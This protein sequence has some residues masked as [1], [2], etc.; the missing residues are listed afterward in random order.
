MPS[1]SARRR[2]RT[3]R[4]R[5]RRALPQA[6]GEAKEWTVFYYHPPGGVEITG[7]VRSTLYGQIRRRD[8][9]KELACF[10]P[11]EGWTFWWAVETLFAPPRP[12]RATNMLSQ[13]KRATNMPMPKIE[14]LIFILSRFCKNIWFATNFA[15]TYICRRGPRLRDITTWPTA[16]GAAGSGPLAWAR[17]GAIHH[18][19]KGLAQWATTSGPSAMSH[20]GSTPASTVGHGAR[21]WLPI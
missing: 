7:A 6:T 10:G 20:D 2:R 14:F 11:S 16:V 18:G 21:V 15:K 13:K 1:A 3:G 4:P 12:Q 8:C 5:G 9:K 17:L 19:A